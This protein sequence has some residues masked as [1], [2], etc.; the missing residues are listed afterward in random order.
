MSDNGTQPTSVA[1]I[2]ACANLGVEQAFTSYNNPKGNANTERVMRTIKE[3]C[4]WL[5]EWEN[6]DQAKRE[7]E[8]YIWDYNNLYPHSTL[9]E[10]SPVEFE[11]QI[12]AQKAA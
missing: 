12:S 2:Q 10:L 4:L 1:F 6:L 8:N 5:T 3:D 11:Q 7:I 9:Q